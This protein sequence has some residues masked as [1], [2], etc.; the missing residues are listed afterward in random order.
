M[1]N[2]LADRVVTRHRAVGAGPVR[3]SIVINIYTPS[4]RQRLVA[5]ADLRSQVV[6]M[7]LVVVDV[8]WIVTRGFPVAQASEIHVPVL[9]EFF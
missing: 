4:G 6:A 9:V 5:S 2:A 3:V 1:L 8:P 7:V